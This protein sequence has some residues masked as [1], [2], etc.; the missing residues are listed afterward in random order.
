MII[1]KGLDPENRRCE[2]GR[3]CHTPVCSRSRSPHMPQGAARNYTSIVNLTRSRR[4]AKPQIASRTWNPRP[5]PC[6]H[7]KFVV[8]VGKLRTGLQRARVYGKPYTS[9]LVVHDITSC[10]FKPFSPPKPSDPGSQ[11]WAVGA[12]RCCVTQHKAPAGRGRSP[13]TGRVDL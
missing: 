2:N 1:L 10:L 5:C 4:P 13:K 12:V 11:I 3:K 8:N 7:K 9:G 6:R